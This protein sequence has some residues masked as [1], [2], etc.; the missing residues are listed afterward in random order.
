MK[1]LINSARWLL[2][3]LFWVQASA[4][5]AQSGISRTDRC[6]AI[7]VQLNG[8]PLGSPSEIVVKTKTSSD[9]IS[10]QGCFNIPPWIFAQQPADVSFEIA[11]NRIHLSEIS[12]GFFAGSWDIEL[13]DHSFPSGTVVPK[14]AHITELCGVVFHV[15]DPEIGMVQTRCRS[16]TGEA[17]Q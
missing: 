11:G 1:S 17:K 2:A 16:R 4:S 14:N 6:M 13:E 9:T 10:G 8:Q 15:G 7:H 5:L 3:L 12:T